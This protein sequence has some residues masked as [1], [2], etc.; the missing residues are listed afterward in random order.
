MTNGYMYNTKKNKFP[1]FKIL[2]I[3]LLTLSGTGLALF[4]SKNI[5]ASSENDKLRMQI[6]NV[7]VQTEQLLSENNKLSESIREKEQL[8][9]EVTKNQKIAYLTFDDGPSNNTEE[10][11]AVLNKYNVK[12][13]F[14]VIGNDRYRDKY[15][16]ILQSGHKIALHSYTHKYEEIYKSVDSFKSDIQQ[17]KDYI[18][19]VTGEVPENILRYPGGSTNTKSYKIG[20]PDIMKSI[21]DAMRADNYAYYD[22]N[23]DSED[24]SG[25]YMPKDTIVANVLKESKNKKKPVILF[26][27]TNAKSTTV[28]ALPEIIENLINE[29]FTFDVLSMNTSIK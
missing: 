19:G 6:D 3:I 12:A 2:I 23:V 10:I 22:W 17:L 28:Q 11:L 24:A 4:E 7:K 29:G 8:Y 21:I 5:K 26:H 15:S 18:T 25:K 16:K 9:K 27:D 13:T 14:F 20:G 1:Y